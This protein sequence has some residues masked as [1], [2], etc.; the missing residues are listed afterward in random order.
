MLSA[1]ALAHYLYESH[2]T[3]QYRDARIGEYVVLGVSDTGSGMD[4]EVLSHIF[5]PFFTTKE[6]EEGTGLGLATVYGIVQQN[7]GL[8]L[9][10]SIIGKGTTFKLFFPPPSTETR[11]DRSTGNSQA[12]IP[13]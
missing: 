13:G 5:E 7:K 6:S 10:E 2:Q 12:R 8:I 1:Y 4:D 9:V 3:K 11:L